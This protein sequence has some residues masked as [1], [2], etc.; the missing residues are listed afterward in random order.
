MKEHDYYLLVSESKIGVHSENQNGSS[1]QFEVFATSFFPN[2]IKGEDEE[3]RFSIDSKNQVFN[4]VV[5]RY[6]N[7]KSDCKVYILIGFDLDLTGEAMSTAFRD[8]LIDKQIPRD[9][10]V[11]TPLTEQGYIAFKNFTEGKKYKEYLY[12]QKEFIDIQRKNGIKNPMGFQKAISL[13]LLSEHKGRETL[14]DSNLSTSAGKSTVTVV[15]NFLGSTGEYHR[16]Q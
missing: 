2:V 10:I 7:L 4:D 13:E 3:L 16:E 12:L 5:E 6:H 11:R 14:V 1:S 8:A 15:M 9:V